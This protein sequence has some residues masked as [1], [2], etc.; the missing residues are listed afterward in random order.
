MSDYTIQ[1]V[2]AQFLNQQFIDKMN[3]GLTKEA[4]AAMSA[5]VRL[6]L[7]EESFARKIL[8]PQSVT[9]AD[10]DRGLDDQP[11][12]IVEKE[13][14]SV[15][16]SISLSGNNEVR[17][18]QGARYPVNFYKIESPTFKK[19]K[20]ELATYR[21]DIRQILQDNSV[22]DLH[23]QEDVNFWNALNVIAANGANG[24]PVYDETT[25]FSPETLMTQIAKLAGFEQ[26]PGK[27][28]MP[29]SLYLKL[30]GTPA[31]TIGD[32]AAT[33]HFRG[34]PMDGFYGFELIPT[35][36]HSILTSA[37]GDGTSVAVFA[38]E[39]YLGQYYTLE[40]ATVF[41]KA[42]KDMIEFTTYESV[43]MGIG[44]VKGFQITKYDPTP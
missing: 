39:N 43:G 19:S 38:P 18:F 11:Q 22:K 6:K 28:L 21:T 23:K 31:T 35:I 32:L 12:I 33:E 17:Y 29:M 2:N 26:K 15:A 27:V 36:K 30:L 8:T 4:G 1:N 3:Q 34:G 10:L 5:F 13:I 7:R 37:Y 20:Y 16:A 9:A 24:N 40:D 44:N 42:E 25:G 41:L 14:D